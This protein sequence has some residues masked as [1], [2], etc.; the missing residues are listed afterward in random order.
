M[1]INEIRRLMSEHGESQAHLARLLGITADKMS[2]TLNGSRRITVQES[3]TLRRY[4]Q[5]D[6]VPEVRTLPIVELV[7][8]GTWWEEL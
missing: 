3:E 8:A 7:S 2:K 1:D 4:Y 6:Q 5:A